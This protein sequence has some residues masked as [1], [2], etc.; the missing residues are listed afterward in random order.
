M[1][2]KSETQSAES[3][4]SEN[5]PQNPHSRPISSKGDCADDLSPSTLPRPR[6]LIH[7]I[8][9]NV[10]ED[11]GEGGKEI[12]IETPRTPSPVL[13][14]E[15][16][17]ASLKIA[18]KAP[19]VTAK[20]ATAPSPVIEEE[21]HKDSSSQSLTLSTKTQSQD[22][23]WVDG[24][25][26]KPLRFLNAR[27][28]TAAST[29]KTTSKRPSDLMSASLTAPAAKRPYVSMARRVPSSQTRNRSGCKHNIC[30]NQDKCFAT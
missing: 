1:T 18:S 23:A 5:E 10:D 14:S 22:S 3:D 29:P 17:E 11:E 4:R 8:E 16:Q 26:D 6:S 25:N 9:D 27:L 21:H 28:Q 30:V 15:D 13:Q 12:D 2:I 20:D 19:V 24:R 7:G